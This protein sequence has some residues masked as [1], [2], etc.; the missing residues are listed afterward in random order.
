MQEVVDTDLVAVRDRLAQRLSE[1]DEQ[2]KPLQSEHARI[3]TQLDLIGRALTVNGPGAIEP[4]PVAPSAPAGGTR[5]TVND[6]I[7]NILAEAGSPLHISE[8]RK[9]Y[10]ATGR[11][12]PGRGT[13]SNLLIC[14]VRDSRFRRV[15]KGTYTLAD[16]NSPVAENQVPKRNVKSR[17]RRRKTKSSKGVK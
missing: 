4:E 1:L 11:T 2:L 13:E 14:M 3:K 5:K 12:I 16:G 15:S 10:L 7:S 9:R 6:G 17:R 8:I